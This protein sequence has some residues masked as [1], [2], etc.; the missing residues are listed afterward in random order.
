MMKVHKVNSSITYFCVIFPV[1]LYIHLT[2]TD[3]L[4]VKFLRLTQ[5]EELEICLINTSSI[6]LQESLFSRGEWGSTC[7]L[8]IDLSSQLSSTDSWDSDLSLPC[9]CSGHY[10]GKNSPLRIWNFYSTYNILF[11][12]M[13]G[14][15]FLRI[16]MVKI[17]LLES[18]QHGTKLITEKLLSHYRIPI[19]PFRPTHGD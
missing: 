19:I 2:K 12:Y 9:L 5:P 16:M 15:I 18:K 13:Y 14:C 1:K 10:I 11:V 17:I 6:E 8:V 4:W 7:S 3:H